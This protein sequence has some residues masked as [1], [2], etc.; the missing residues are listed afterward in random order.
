MKL[1]GLMVIASDHKWPVYQH[2]APHLEDSRCGCGNW[3]LETRD[4]SDLSWCV[5]IENI[6][7]IFQWYI[8]CIF[9][10]IYIY[11]Y[12]CVY[13]WYIYILYCIYIY[14]YIPTWRCPVIRWHGTILVVGMISQLLGV[15]DMIWHDYTRWSPQL[16]PQVS[17][18]S[19]ILQL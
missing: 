8:M 3:D 7:G 6:Q 17:W 16:F 12:V 4:G 15:I 13:L 10:F 11:I 19:N 18:Y 9:V 14:I 5:L 1:D 2:L